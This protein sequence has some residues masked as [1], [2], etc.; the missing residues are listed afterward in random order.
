M[1]KIN[2]MIE[3]HE[4]AKEIVRLAKGST[5]KRLTI[6]D[7]KRILSLLPNAVFNLAVEGKSCRIQGLVD[8][9]VEYK[10]ERQRKNPKTKEEITVAPSYVMKVKKS[11][12]LTQKLKEA[13]TNIDPS[14]ILAMDEEVEGEDVE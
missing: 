1:A 4:L 13:T 14:A 12:T 7:T 11:R 3:K 9:I 5:N 10:G 2:N 8:F 6:E